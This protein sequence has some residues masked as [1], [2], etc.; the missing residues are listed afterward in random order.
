MPAFLKR[1]SWSCC[2]PRPQLPY[3][4]GP[5]VRQVGAISDPTLLD[6]HH[7]EQEAIA[8]ARVLG[9]Q[10]LLT[11]DYRARISAR[12]HGLATLTTLLILDA[13]ADRS[14]ISLREALDRLL[15]TNFRVDQLTIEQLVEKHR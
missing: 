10:F 11:D 9:A 13:A 4:S 2:T 8:L 6:L 7:G 3:A 15:K 12:N 14:W 1:C 5:S